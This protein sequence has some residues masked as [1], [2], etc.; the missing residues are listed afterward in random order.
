M[1]LGHAHM[2]QAHRLDLEMDA[3]PC[4]LE[5]GERPWVRAYCA[6]GWRGRWQPT[7]RGAT[8]QAEREHVVLAMM[9]LRDRR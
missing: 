9:K 2:V 7:P 1:A 4:D 6:C 3:R 5:E 8:L